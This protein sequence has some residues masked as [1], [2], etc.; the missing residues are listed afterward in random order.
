M[1]TKIYNFFDNYSP[2]IFCLFSLL[3][4][5]FAMFWFSSW[6]D[7]V[8]YRDIDIITKT[9]YYTIFNSC[10]QFNNK[11]YCWEDK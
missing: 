10:R 6:I 1:F 5:F 2:L 3:I 4:A 7:R 11:F 9:K 8:R